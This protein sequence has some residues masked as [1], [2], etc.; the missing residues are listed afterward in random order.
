MK[1]TKYLLAFAFM[2]S[3]SAGSVSYAQDSP[4]PPASE[5]TQTQIDPEKEAE[6]QKQREQEM[7][8]AAEAE[9]PKK[10]SFW[11]KFAFWK[12]KPKPKPERE[13]N[14][15]V[16]SL[17]HENLARYM[18]VND[19]EFYRFGYARKG[20]QWYPVFFLRRF[21]MMQNQYEHTLIVYGKPQ[22][23][24]R[25]KGITLGL[26]GVEVTNEGF[27]YQM[28]TVASVSRSQKQ[29]DDVQSLDLASNRLQT[30]GFEQV[31]WLKDKKKETRDLA[32]SWS[33]TGENT[34]Q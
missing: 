13:Y 14:L 20:I 22:K 34:Q 12:K 4:P 23:M 7:K 11:S 2:L 33:L 26:Y 32:D 19:D 30:F 10:E 28:P 5:Q 8:A 17:W 1:I 6:Y 9:K 29:Y 24:P 16:E 21:K 3:L 15:Q 18:G 31:L 27:E 25:V